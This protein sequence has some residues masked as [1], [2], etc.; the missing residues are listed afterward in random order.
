MSDSTSRVLSAFVVS[1]ALVASAIALAEPRY[2]GFSVEDS[3]EQ[4]IH[5]IL[6]IHTGRVC[7]SV[8]L[9]NLEELEEGSRSEFLRC[10]PELENFEEQ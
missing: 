6:D 8:V 4:K 10:A 1:V 9:T 7:Y 3:S 5:G 2:E